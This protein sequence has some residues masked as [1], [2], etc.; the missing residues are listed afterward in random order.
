MKSILTFL[1]FLCGHL[2]GESTVVDVAGCNG[3]VSHSLYG[4]Q[5]GIKT[6]GKPEGSQQ[7]L[8]DSHPELPGEN[9]L[10]FFEED[11]SEEEFTRKPKSSTEPVSL[12]FTAFVAA[13]PRRKISN[14]VFFH[15]HQSY[16]STCKYL[17][18]GVLRI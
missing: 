1:F 11:D 14:Q 3:K 13:H 16:T 5:D 10:L 2:S 15:Y 8:L 6:F 9:D 17:A 18:H 4:Q 7:A 12:F